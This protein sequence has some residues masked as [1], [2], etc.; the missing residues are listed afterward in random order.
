MASYG[1]K[2]YSMLYLLIGLVLLSTIYCKP[3][4]LSNNKLVKKLE[5]QLNKQN[6]F[7]NVEDFSENEIKNLRDLLAK[8]GKPGMDIKP[9]KF[10]KDTFG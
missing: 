9:N 10:G 5:S 6:V 3:I 1:G 7:I 2:L 8:F 4:G